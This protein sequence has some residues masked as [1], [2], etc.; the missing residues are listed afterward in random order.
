[1]T[2]KETIVELLRR[3]REAECTLV[4]SGEGS[5]GNTPQM[6]LSWNASYRELERC[7]HVLS[8]ERPKQT[9]MLLARYV[10]A[11]QSR[12]RLP[13]RRNGR[14]ELLFSPGPHREVRASAKLPD[15]DR[16]FNEWDVVVLSWPAWVRMPLVNAALDRLVEVF[17][18]EP[19]LPSEMVELEA[20][21]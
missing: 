4:K 14:G 1:M 7:L 15:A 17:E 9:R 11:V 18:G 13:G 19:Y 6:P 2:R 5:G 3:F 16:G 10:D 20:A 12:K 8:E 21:A